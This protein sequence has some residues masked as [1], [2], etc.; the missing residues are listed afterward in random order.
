MLRRAQLGG[1]HHISICWCVH[2][3]KT[4]P[5]GKKI[6]SIDE[7]EMAKMRRTLITEL[8]WPRLIVSTYHHWQSSYGNLCL[9]FYWPFNFQKFPKAI[10]INTSKIIRSESIHSHSTCF[11]KIWHPLGTEQV[12]ESENRTPPIWKPLSYPNSE[13]NKKTFLR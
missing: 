11:K 10:K 2:N 5:I 9:I 8:W 13:R 7:W 1:R 4:S 6:D 3:D 12:T